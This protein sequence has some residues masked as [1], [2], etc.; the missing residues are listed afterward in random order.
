[1]SDNN[2]ENISKMF[3]PGDII[4]Y[5]NGDSYELGEVK[6]FHP[7]TNCYFVYYHT[8]DTAALTPV[9][10]MHKIVNGYAYDIT[11]N[12]ID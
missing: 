8:G 3:N 12:T 7:A 5:R 9:S 4:I 1:M 2:T 6:H 10:N 11:R